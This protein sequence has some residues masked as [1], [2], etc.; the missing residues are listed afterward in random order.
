MTDQSKSFVAIPLQFT[1]NINFKMDV[2]FCWKTKEKYKYFGCS[3][4]IWVFLSIQYVCAL[5]MIFIYRSI[6]LIFS[7][8]L[9]ILVI[10]CF[11]QW[12]MSKNIAAIILIIFNLKNKNYVFIRCG[13]IFSMK[14]SQVCLK[15][16]HFFSIFFFY[17]IGWYKFRKN[18]SFIKNITLFRKKRYY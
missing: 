5:Q 15:R 2:L 3:L 7:F 1:I 12:L 11:I 13:D 6:S 9:E 16:K 10:L 17:K 18:D 14:I 4:K 8:V